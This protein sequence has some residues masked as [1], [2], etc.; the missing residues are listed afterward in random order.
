MGVCRQQSS[1]RGSRRGLGGAEHLRGGTPAAGGANLTDGDGGGGAERQPEEGEGALEVDDEPDGQ[2]V[3]QGDRQR[4]AQL[5][6]Q[7]EGLRRRVFGRQLGC[8]G[9]RGGTGPGL[10]QRLEPIWPV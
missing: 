7:L 3:G 1:R 10:E 6:Q 4:H 8:V 5:L 9:P 2:R